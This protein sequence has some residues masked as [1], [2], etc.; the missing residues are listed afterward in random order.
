MSYLNK[1]SKVPKVPM[2]DQT[3]P[4]RSPFVYGRRLVPIVPQTGR[5]YAPVP[6]YYGQHNL[7]RHNTN[8]DKQQ[9]VMAAPQKPSGILPRADW[10]RIQSLL[11]QPKTKM[12]TRQEMVD[13]NAERQ[14]SRV[15]NKIMKAKRGGIQAAIQ[16]ERQTEKEYFDEIAAEE[17]DFKKQKVQEAL[18][19]ARTKRLHQDGSVRTF[20]SAILR[21]QMQTENELLIGLKK[22]KQRCAE[23][24]ERQYVI[25]MRRREEEVLIQEQ[26]KASQKQTNIHSVTNYRSE[27]IKKKQQLREEERQ[28]EKEERDQLRA[29]AA[30]HEQ[31]LRH[32]Q[33]KKVESK[34][35][36]LQ[37]RQ[38][39]ISSKILDGAKEA[40][41]G[42]E[43]KRQRVQVDME[44]KLQQRKMDQAEKFQKLQVTKQMVYQKLAASKKKQAA[45]SSHEELEKLAR[46][47]TE[48]DSKVAKQLKDKEESRAAMLKTI[49][50]HRHKKVEE[51]EQKRKEEQQSK[52]DWCQ[53]HKVSE[54][55]FLEE[56]KQKAQRIN[57]NQI[58]CRGTN[59]SLTAEKHA[60][61]QQLERQDREAARKQAEQIAEEDKLVQQYVQRELHKAAD[62]DV[63]QLLAASTGRRGVLSKRGEPS[64][65]GVR[66]EE[67][68]PRYGTDQ[69]RF[70]KRYQERN[71]LQLSMD[72]E[73]VH[74][75]PLTRAA[76]LKSAEKGSRY[77]PK[78]TCVAL[79]R[80]I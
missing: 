38:R 35:R 58:S 71:S 1:D 37:L 51:K 28:K 62:R 50:N 25:K 17:T 10:E 61:L 31:E 13:R 33:E 39:E 46:A 49:V 30:L 34:K 64:Y 45:M 44:E 67:P 26:K 19:D 8:L 47:T 80:L 55:L 12:S 23:E 75:P 53:A 76:Q 18:A 43:D 36:L 74:L 42:E 15:E 41:K 65:F 70:I 9:R 66:S 11:N 14:F 73:P 6:D 22:E 16:L 72:T 57:E 20:N 48:K 21:T 32:E 24:R 79:P 68:L 78:S 56:K 5:Q 7:R 60:R 77:L 59:A 54:R 63:Q 52:L 3:E 4:K 27:Q 40:R 69:T 29:L 2:Y